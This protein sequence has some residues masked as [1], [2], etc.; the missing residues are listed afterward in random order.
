MVG[1]SVGGW[2]Q[3]PRNQQTQPDILSLIRRFLAR[4]CSTKSSRIILASICAP[5]VGQKKHEETENIVN[6]VGFQNKLHHAPRHIGSSL[7][8]L[9]LFSSLFC[10]SFALALAIRPSIS[11]NNHH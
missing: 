8:S 7:H 11:S 3:G 5:K 9:S 2:G 1:G 10:Q 4:A 6:Y